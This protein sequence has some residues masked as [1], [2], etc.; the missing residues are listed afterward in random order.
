MEILN[1][2]RYL[3]RV[4]THRCDPLFGDLMW[5]L[6]VYSPGLCLKKFAPSP[7]K[8]AWQ[9]VCPEPVDGGPH[10]IKLKAG[11]N[12]LHENPDNATLSMGQSHRDCNSDSGYNL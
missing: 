1:G 2:S 4:A 9:Q 7:W 12:R 3:H 6:V 10:L 5:L 8:I 11:K